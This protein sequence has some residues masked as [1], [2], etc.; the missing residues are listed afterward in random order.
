MTMFMALIM[1]FIAASPMPGPGPVVLNELYEIK[2]PPGGAFGAPVE[3]TVDNKGSLFVLDTL[4]EE[5]SRFDKAGRFISS[6][7]YRAVAGAK[8]RPLGAIF[9]SGDRLYILEGSN[10][11]IRDLN[12]GLIREVPTHIPMPKV[13]TF[14]FYVQDGYIVISGIKDGSKDFF[15]ILDD[16]GKEIGSFGGSFAVPDKIRASLPKDYDPRNLSKPLKIFYS[17]TE[18]ELFVLNP[19]QYEIQ[20]YRGRKLYRT[21]T[22][23][24]TYGGFA[25][26]YSTSISTGQRMEYAP[27][28]IG[29]PLVT[30]R[31]RCILIL[32]AKSWGSD[33]Y[34]VDIF[35]NYVYRATQDVDIKGLPVASD[36]EGNVYFINNDRGIASIIKMKM[37]L[38]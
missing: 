10:I 34:C 22:H 30:R 23:D 36:E 7:D 31:G 19:F 27:A 37:N 18:N 9:A 15:H 1:L 11:V 2:G 6:I 12:G 38:N 32:R 14:T 33:N 20:V 24:A 5:I 21:L 16:Y 29:N 13:I 28:Y 35:K 4:K 8:P 17:A 3:I 26:G 25:G